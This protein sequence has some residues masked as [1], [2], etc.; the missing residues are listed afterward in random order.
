MPEIA[1]LPSELYVPSVAQTV[2]EYE[3]ENERGT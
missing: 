1:R 2:H 3:L